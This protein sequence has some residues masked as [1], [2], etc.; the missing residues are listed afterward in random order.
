MIVIGLTGPSGSGKSTVSALFSARGIPV[1]DADAVYRELLI[2]P[3]DCLDELVRVFGN[4]ILCPNGTLNRRALGKLVFSD[5]EALARLNT[6]AH[7][8]IMAEIHRRIA[9]FRESGARAVLLDA[10]QLFEAD[11]ARDCDAVVSVLADEATRLSRI[12]RRDGITERD[13]RL[14]MNVQ[15]SD[16]F[17]RERSD[18]VLENNGD[19]TALVSAVDTILRELKIAPLSSENQK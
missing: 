5:R 10:P 2:P 4:E 17:F 1:I 12:M 8:H 7:R 15:Y 14:R 19:T 18:Y 6:V 9:A 3:S 11:A 16:A 13:A